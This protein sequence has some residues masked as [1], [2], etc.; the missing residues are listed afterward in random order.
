MEFPLMFYSS[1][2]H[3]IL[4]LGAFLS[5]SLI[6][7]GSS[8][9]LLGSRFDA[10]R[11]YASNNSFFRAW[12]TKS[13][14]YFCLVAFFAAGQLALT[15]IPAP[16]GTAE[17]CVASAMESSPAMLTAHFFV[18]LS[19]AMMSFLH[20]RMCAGLNLMVDSFCEDIKMGIDEITAASRWNIIYGL[21]NKTTT[22]IGT[23]F[24]A[25]ISTFAAALALAAADVLVG[26]VKFGSV[27][28][29]PWLLN[30]LAPTMLGFL[31]PFVALIESGR[32]T[33]KCS[34][35]AG[36]VSTARYQE[37][38]LQ[39]AARNLQQYLVNFI[40]RTSSGFLIHGVQVTTFVAFK[41]GSAMVTITFAIWARGQT[42]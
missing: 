34:R 39:D 33:A 10:I 29:V 9:A 3:V 24:L 40:H 4:A 36:F 23:A 6:W 21:I 19:M 20:P 18:V 13:F 5:R 14:R 17:E 37:G 30:W 1:F 41:L 28:A 25:Q 35:V 26:N 22:T 42:I 15:L 8:K 27:C 38:S 7:E 16:R 12:R 31:M 32:F 2:T 11:I